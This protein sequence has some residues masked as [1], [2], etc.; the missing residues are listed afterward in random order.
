MD[1]KE[2]MNKKRFICTVSIEF[3]LKNRHMG[4]GLAVFYPHI[5]ETVENTWMFI[6]GENGLSIRIEGR[7]LEVLE[8]DEIT[9]HLSIG[10]SDCDRSE[11]F[12]MPILG[13]D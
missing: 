7:S 5:A 4:T 1:L 9:G 6:D 3:G 13:V 8:Y 11:K 12:D 10:T 2:F